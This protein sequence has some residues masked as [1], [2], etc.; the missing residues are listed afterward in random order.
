MELKSVPCSASKMELKSDPSSAKKMELKSVQDPL[1]SELFPIL[2]S[3][4]FL[5]FFL[6]IKLIIADKEGRS[7]GGGRSRLEGRP[8]K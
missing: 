2:V 5:F 8:S 1:I 3:H 6:Q 4:F 7:A